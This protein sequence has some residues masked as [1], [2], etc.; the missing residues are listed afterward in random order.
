VNI[1][2]LKQENRALKQA[3]AEAQREIR[4]LA[5]KL[6]RVHEAS[7]PEFDSDADDDH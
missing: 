3:L 1:N 5:R 6:A 7:A 2:E 4:R